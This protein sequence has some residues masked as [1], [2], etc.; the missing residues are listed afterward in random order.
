MNAKSSL[1]HL[2]FLGFNMRA[3]VLHATKKI[4]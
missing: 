2:D 1:K 4:S 3:L